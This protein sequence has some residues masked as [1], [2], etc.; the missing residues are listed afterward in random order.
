MKSNGGDRTDQKHLCPL[1]K[2]P[3]SNDCYCIKMD[4]MSVQLAIA[5]CAKNYQIC[6]IYKENTDIQKKFLS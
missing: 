6:D 2:D 5:Y 4:S 3:P 1:I